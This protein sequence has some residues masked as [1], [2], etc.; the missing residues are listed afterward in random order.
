MVQTSIH[1]VFALLDNVF[2]K[3]RSTDPVKAA[4]ALEGMKIKSFNGDAE[5]TGYMMAPMKYSEP[6]VASRPTSCQ[7]KRPGAL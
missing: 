6:Y 3:T 4:A 2:A 1:H 7:T 5:N